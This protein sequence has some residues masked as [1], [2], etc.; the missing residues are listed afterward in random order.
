[1]SDLNRCT[2]I[3]RLGR[4]PELRY[5]ASGT[6][7]VNISIACGEKWKDKQT[8]EMQER[9]EWI[10]VV[11]FGRRAEVVAE[12]CRKGSQV[13]IEGKFRTRKWQDN[14]GNDRWTTEV[15]ADDIKLLGSPR[16]GGG[17]QQQQYN[18]PQQRGAQRQQ[19]QRQQPQRQQ[20]DPD[21]FDD[22]IPF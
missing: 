4:D 1:M 21:A 22:D 16:N 7:I 8:G 9:T 19:P 15:H 3:G 20:P 14:N 2:F 5:A 13:Y 18:P 17:G 11:L 12:Y 10:N 6:A